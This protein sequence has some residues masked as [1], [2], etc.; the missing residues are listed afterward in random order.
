MN[1]VANRP[2]DFGD[3]QVRI[4][5][6]FRIAPEDARR[7]YRMFRRGRAYP[8]TDRTK[9]WTCKEDGRMFVGGGEFGRD[10]SHL[11]AHIA[12]AYPDTDPEPEDDS[13][14]TE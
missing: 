1:F 10:K 4:G 14:D 7:A 2:I 12:E 11:N 9:V 5:E 13:D 8:L 3:Y 6:V